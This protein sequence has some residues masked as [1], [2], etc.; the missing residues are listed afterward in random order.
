MVVIIKELISELKV[1]RGGAPRPMSAATYELFL[2]N[3]TNNTSVALKPAPVVRKCIWT[4]MTNLSMSGSKEE[5]PFPV[6]LTHID[7]DG[8]LHF[9]Q[10]VAKQ[11]YERDLGA[12]L[13]QML[14]R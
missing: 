8:Y 2:N 11:Y 13:Y 5:C 12:C 1:E 7:D 14:L 9:N 10:S 3:N 4:E 6:T